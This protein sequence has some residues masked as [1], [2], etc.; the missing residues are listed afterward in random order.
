MRRYLNPNFLLIIVLLIGMTVANSNFTNPG[1]WFLTRLL[2]LPGIVIGLSVHEFGH[3]I[4]ALKLGDNTPHMQ[5]RITLNPIAHIDLFGFICLLVAGFGWGKPVMINPQNFKNR[6][7]DE[8][9]V[10]IAGVVMNFIF[11]FIFAI[12]VN[13]LILILVSKGA[14]YDQKEVIQ[15]FANVVQINIVL[16]VF[17]L[18]PIPPLDG[19]GIVTE[20]FD[21][22][23]NPWYY[24]VYENG[25]IILMILLVIGLVDRVVFPIV[26]AVYTSVL[27]LANQIVPVDVLGQ[28][29]I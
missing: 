10:S 27:F 11:A 14:Y 19:F 28:I 20:L 3:A 25:F 9:L 22:R 24:R 16:M 12:I 1:E 4:V 8:F 2:L 13:L 21:L 5:G 23:K 26:H 18:L 15:V 7:R 6:R 17:N 29:F